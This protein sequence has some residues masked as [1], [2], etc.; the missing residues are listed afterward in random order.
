LKWLAVASS[1]ATGS[2]EQHS[3]L[4]LPTPIT[5]SASA[6]DGGSPLAGLNPPSPE[7][8]CS[9][10]STLIVQTVVL[11]LKCDW[12]MKMTFGKRGRTPTE[13]QSGGAGNDGTIRSGLGRNHRQEA[14]IKELS[15]VKPLN[16]SF[17]WE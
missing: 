12:F 11:I 4:P 3:A 7:V 6:R 15:V 5:S 13:P 8:Q 2:I 10:S 16:A 9:A 17:L 14:K 1:P